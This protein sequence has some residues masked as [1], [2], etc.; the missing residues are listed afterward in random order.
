MNSSYS[1][2]WDKTLMLTTMPHILWNSRLQA[3]ISAVKACETT[4][5]LINCSMSSTFNAY[6]LK[7]MNETVLCVTTILHDSRL[8]A[9]T[10]RP[11][12]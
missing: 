3:N 9:L 7:K 4:P 1:F 6:K 12:N 5:F 2:S 8:A 11:I 10:V